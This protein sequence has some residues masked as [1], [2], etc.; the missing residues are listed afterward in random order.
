MLKKFL[1]VFLVI[2]LGI[3]VLPMNVFAEELS[4]LD[5]ENEAVSAG[6]FLEQEE[7][8]PYVLYEDTEKRDENTKHFRLSDG[9]YKAVSYSDPV[10]YR[11]N[12]RSEWK[13]IDNTLIE[14]RDEEG[15]SYLA[16]ASS[17]V[18]VELSERGDSDKLVSY[19]IDG[20][21]ISWSYENGDFGLFK[22][23][24]K[25]SK[26]KSEKKA[27][28]Q[29]DIQN[30]FLG[31]LES[32][33]QYD[34]FYDY[35]DIEYVVTPTG[36]KE[37]IILNSNKAQTD[38]DIKYNIGKLTAEQT[39]ERTITLFDGENAVVNISA[40]Y[41]EDA[42]VERS[43]ALSLTIKS[44]SGG[45]LEVSLSADREWLSVANRAYPVTVDPYISKIEK[46]INND[47]SAL[48]NSVSSSKYP[49]GSLFVGKNSA[50]GKCRSYIKCSLPT[51]S[52]GDMVVG[53]Q[54]SLLQFSSA[55]NG[56]SSDASGASSQINISTVSSSWTDN[57]I[58]NSNSFSGLPGSDWVVLD[59]IHTSSSTMGKWASFD[60]GGAVADWYNGAKA[61]NGF[62]LWAQNENTNA[63]TAFASADF[64]EGG[65]SYKPTLTVIYLNNKGLEDR[66]TYH[67]QSLGDSGTSYI[68]DCTGNLVF[69]AP[70]Y[71]GTGNNSPASVSLVYNGYLV[72]N[73]G[74]GQGRAG[75]GW[76]FDFQQ[77][78]IK[79][80]NGASELYTSLYKAGFRYI[81]VD[82][83]GT[84]HYFKAKSGTTTQFE[85]EEGLNYT[86]TVNESSADAK[87]TL[88][89]K[90]GAKNIY[91]SDGCIRKICDADNNYYQYIYDSNNII[92]SIRDGASRTLYISYSGGFV[93]KITDPAGRSTSF[94]YSSNLLTK[95][96]YPDNV[97][98]EFVYDNNRLSKCTGI[99]KRALAFSYSTT[100]DTSAK[101]RVASV[102]ELGADGSALGGKLSIN[103]SYNN[104]TTFTDRQGRSEKFVFDNYG[105]TVCINDADGGG[106]KYSYTNDDSSAKGNK[107][108]A[109]M[110]KTKY[111]DNILTNHSFE[112]GMTNWTVV[113]SSSLGTCT[114]STDSS[115]LGA[116]SLKIAKTKAENL[117][118]YQRLTVASGNIK[119]G[120]TYTFS[121]YVK[122]DSAATASS[123]YANCFLAD[124]QKQTFKS[125]I[126]NETLGEYTRLSVYFT[127]PANTDHTDFVLSAA[128]SGTTYFDCVQLEKGKVVNDYNLLEETNFNNPASGIW[129]GLSLDA[130]DKYDS[131]CY[132]MTGVA[133]KSKQLFQDVKINK[134]ASKCTFSL[135]GT[136]SAT[137]VPVTDK[138]GRYVA[139]NAV[140]YFTDGTTQYTNLMFNSDVRGWQYTT[141]I[142]KAYD[143]NKNKTIDYIRIRLIYYKNAN[144]VYFDKISL[145][146]DETGTSYTYDNNGN[147]IS[148]KDNA[149][150][151]QT[152]T[153]DNAKNLVSANYEDNTSYKYTYDTSGTNKQRLLTAKSNNSNILITYGYNSKGSVNKTTVSAAG[154]SRTIETSAT[155]GNTNQN[156]LLSETDALGNTTSYTYNTNQGTLNTV[157][158][159]AGNKTTYSY[160]TNND[161][162]TRVKS[163]NT[164]INY[165]Y[166]ANRVLEKI[167]TPTVKY[168]FTYDA[169]MNPSTVSV[170]NY[171]LSTNA[172]EANNGNLTKSTY[173]NGSSVNYTYDE[174]DRVVQKAYNDSNG[175]QVVRYN[176]AFNAA[177][178]TARA[179]DSS[180]NLVYNYSYDLSGRPIEMYRNDGS[181]IR[182]KYD[183]KNLTTGVEYKFGGLTEK[184]F[185][186]YNNSMDNAPEKTTLTNN[187]WVYND[188][189][190]LGRVEKNWLHANG[191]TLLFVYYDYVNS[192]A[193]ADKTSG[194]V[195]KISY[196]N[197]NIKPLEYKYD[198][199][200]NITRIIY[201]NVYYDDYTYD[202]QNKLIRVDSERNDETVVYSYDYNGNIERKDRYTCNDAEEELSVKT[203][204]E[205][206]HYIYEDYYWQDKLTEYN[207][208]AITY[209]N[210]GNPLS[211]DG[212]TFTWLGRRMMSYKKGSTTTSYKYN[213]DGIRTT[214]TVGST[215]TKYFLDGSTIL[216]QQTGSNTMPFYYDANGKRVAFKYNG[217]M[218]FYV[219]N[220]QGDV[221]HI[222]KGDKT[223]VGTYTYDAWGKITNIN[224]LTA[225]AQINPFRY[226]GYYYDS[227]SNLYYLNSRYYNPDWGRF[228]NADGCVSAGLDI[229]DYNMFTYCANNPVSRGDLNGGFWGA[230]IGGIA[231]GVT[232]AASAAIAGDSILIGLGVGIATGAASGLIGDFCVA[233]GG[234]GA[235][236]IA[237]VASGFFDG[238][239]NG[240]NSVLNGNE[241]NWNDVAVDAALGTAFGAFDFAVSGG[242]LKKSNKNVVK[243]LKNEFK[244]KTSLPAKKV[245][246]KIVKP[247][248]KKTAKHI[249]GNLV[250]DI[251]LPIVYASSTEVAKLRLEYWGVI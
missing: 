210:I 125:R 56:F 159:P 165:T 111:V 142:V 36:L 121:A 219:Y 115:Y 28:A 66:W 97:A 2:L 107:L 12:E 47:A 149:D 201:D 144:S 32:K 18:D 59:Y 94:T 192:A 133:T 30:E 135:S 234:V 34:H 199:R 20:N 173:G 10:H 89:F 64:N 183:A 35:V 8:E 195:S 50:Y 155:Y 102:E 72:N 43:D 238:L 41:M 23:S 88:E 231:G 184:M 220:L 227:E 114:A 187:D 104:Y 147:L 216:A 21:S 202:S 91:K 138:N 207:G 209:D 49:H 17:P 161:L 225:I 237:S 25:A 76:R 106:T 117:R 42:D 39:D 236:V 5:A 63:S 61:N 128:G 228:I 37:N 1:S 71:S 178:Q 120:E 13:E 162:L 40:P 248:A 46:N 54:L 157:T 166:S 250:G 200:G 194:L 44:Q 48:Y 205:T 188:Y 118:A 134:P 136:A 77:K 246:N 113:G 212:Q 58:I 22:S 129:N 146:L 215:T 193:D 84:E 126:I 151:N 208:K 171:T 243:R 190:E 241:I 163:G 73:A 160:N 14:N 127:V 53:A 156:E 223:I 68:N 158:D 3:Q 16:P 203:H 87:F 217:E 75:G 81:Y 177:N 206:I 167:T 185:Y 4:Q 109:A 79:I 244:S 130:S 196:S 57:Q 38:F 218:Y 103:Y 242:S 153:Y 176:W 145:N 33:V 110:G 174:L 211:Y 70:I 232:G 99:D 27:V 150:K 140:L 168:N 180:E 124:G 123:I 224:S 98:T 198:S 251:S 226:R 230:I 175:N 191:S 189:D 182:T 132:K 143:S 45:I 164:E 233:T 204:L 137:S 181:Y 82:A 101:N 170:N 141:G 148:A 172:Y 105:R 152:Y 29:T 214:K 239:N 240:L 249:V 116:K 108:T 86:L 139:L 80:N 119:I 247:M 235:F 96:T 100:G 122:T 69:I 7:S 95:I 213:W 65:N 112:N 19:N 60:V 9:T 85:D 67:S 197:S 154:T 11:K 245:H 229:T 179:Y 222:M 131:S 55:Y 92:T 186:E 52:A 62:V 6:S 15:N 51:L 90:S 83:D 93:S 221:T 26:V 169:F 74:L 31:N 24:A 78:I